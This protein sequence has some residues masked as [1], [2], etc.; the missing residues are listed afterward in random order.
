M[1]NVTSVEIIIVNAT[2][3]V[4]LDLAA[5]PA[6]TVRLLCHFFASWQGELAGGALLTCCGETGRSAVFFISCSKFF[7]LHVFFMF[8]LL[9]VT[10]THVTL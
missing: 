2:Y 4:R 9:L 8:L 6:P 10:V 3:C 1:P 5:V 7:F